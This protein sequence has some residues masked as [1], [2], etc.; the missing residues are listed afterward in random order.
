MCSIRARRLSLVWHR[1][2]EQRET[3]MMK[4]ISRVVSRSGWIWVTS[5]LPSSLVFFLSLN[6]LTANIRLP[7]LVCHTSYSALAK[8]SRGYMLNPVSVRVGSTVGS[9]KEK[10][11]SAIHHHTS[12][13]AVQPARA[14]FARS[15]S[16]PWTEAMDGAGCCA[17]LRCLRSPARALSRVPKHAAGHGS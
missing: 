1:E 8:R 17:P 2:R 11:P 14:L 7:V 3:Q 9:K 6:T 15:P 4:V 16:F 5:D 10:E 13:C 12:R